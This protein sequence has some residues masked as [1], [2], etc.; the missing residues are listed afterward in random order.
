MSAQKFTLTPSEWVKQPGE[1]KC[2]DKLTGGSGLVPVIRPTG[3][4]THGRS[5]RELQAS[6]DLWVRYPPWDCR[7]SL[8]GKPQHANEN[9]DRPIFSRS[10]LFRLW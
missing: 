6:M 5:W 4:L 7:G 10:L 1:M 2:N 9:C 8:R 3:G